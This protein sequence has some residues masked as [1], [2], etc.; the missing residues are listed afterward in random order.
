MVQQLGTSRDT[1][2]LRGQ[3]RCQLEVVHELEGKIQAE[4]CGLQS[5]EMKVK[6]VCRHPNITSVV[7]IVKLCII[8]ARIFVGRS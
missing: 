4:V 3:C 8:V 2:E 5:N 6:L 1:K 7:S